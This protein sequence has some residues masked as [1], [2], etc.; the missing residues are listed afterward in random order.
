MKQSISKWTDL[1]AIV[2]RYQAGGWVF[3]GVQDAAH[4][5]IP[6]IGRPGSRKD[7]VGGED[8][9]F[10]RAEEEHMLARFQRETRPHLNTSAGTPLSHD[11]ELRAAATSPHL[12]V[13]R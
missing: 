2:E 6:A 11:W 1:A 3:R 9:P 5:L 10:D 4:Q 13:A 7:L 8:L 12:S